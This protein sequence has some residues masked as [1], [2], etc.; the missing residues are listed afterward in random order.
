LWTAVFAPTNAAFAALPASAVQFLQ[1][2]PAVLA[3]VLLYHA[4]DGAVPSS[5]I[6]PDPLTVAT[7]LPGA[8]VVAQRITDAN[9]EK[10]VINES[11][12]VIPDVTATNGVIHAIDK[13]LLPPGIP[14][15]DIVD[16][17]LYNNLNTLARAVT[18]ANLVNVLK[19][20]GPFTV[21]APSEDAWKA[22]PAGFLET[23]LLPE[24]EPLLTSI[25]QYH[26]IAGAAVDAASIVSGSDV[27][28]VSGNTVRLTVSGGAVTVNDATVVMADV[29]A[30][31]GI[32]HVIDS[33]YEWNAHHCPV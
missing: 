19:G 14:L 10:V 25:L 21:F 2:N 26:V 18:E 1:A 7:L 24:N 28:T 31:N 15:L 30:T 27:E 33:K 13:V 3:Q 20:T 6:G 17:A 22:L 32:V 8:N 11:T 12:V 16:L 4:V 23:L 9:G 5:A 29:V